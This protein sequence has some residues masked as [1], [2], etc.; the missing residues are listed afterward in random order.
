MRIGHFS[1]NLNFNQ[2]SESVLFNDSGWLYKEV[3][4]NDYELFWDPSLNQDY[5]VTS[6]KQA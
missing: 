4:N 5:E 1:K 2:N 6:N 3:Q